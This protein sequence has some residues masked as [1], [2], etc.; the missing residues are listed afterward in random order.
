MCETLSVPLL[1]IDVDSERLALM[2]KDAER[3][4]EVDRES[5]VV[6]DVEAE[7]VREKVS[8][9][10]G[11]MEDVFEQLIVELGENDDVDDI[12]AVCDTLK[13]GEKEALADC[14]TVCDFDVED[15]GENVRV[16]EMEHELVR[17]TDPDTDSDG[18]NVCDKVVEELEDTV[19]DR[20]T[21]LDDDTEIEVDGQVEKLCDELEDKEH[22]GVRDADAEND[23]DPVIEKDDETLNDFDADCV[24][25]RLSEIDRDVVFVEENEVLALR[26]ELKLV[27]REN[28]DEKLCDCV[29]DKL[30]LEETLIVIVPLSDPL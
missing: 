12:V 22:E 15:E 1:V 27:E 23:I 25:D 9:L 10:L 20:V 14:V 18:V 8:V 17:V 26:E 21:L 16:G 4:D 29:L 24:N 5:D 7:F 30:E 11:V 6:H 3:V 2:V 13:D 19:A 28:V